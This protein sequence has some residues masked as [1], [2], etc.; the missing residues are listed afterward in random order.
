MDAVFGMLSLQPKTLTVDATAGGSYFGNSGTRYIFYGG[1]FMTASG[2][3]VTGNVDIQVT[4]YLQKGDMIFSKMLPISNGAPLISGGE[5]NVLATQN[6]QPVY[7]KTHNLFVANLPQPGTPDTAMNFFAS[8]PN[9]DT[10]TIKTNWL[11]IAKDTSHYNVKI[12]VGSGDTLTMFSD[13]MKLC[14][15]DHFMTSYSYQNF[16]LAITMSGSPAVS[17]NAIYAYALYD[18]YKGAWPVHS[19]GSEN[20]FSV[21]HVPCIPVHFAV[22][23]L[24]KGVFYGGVTGATPVTGSTYTIDLTEQEPF[25][26][27]NLIN[28]L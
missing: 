28:G 25:A 26:F 13:S 18:N 22:F 12:V 8:T 2:A 24:N 11:P 21:D 5:I 7:L 1:S 17:S 14:N 20:S 4:E 27:K 16:T 19:V 23:T 15:A 6:G 3:T 9:L 10:T